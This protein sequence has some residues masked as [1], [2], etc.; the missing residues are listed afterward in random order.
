MEKFV[1]DG[2]ALMAIR[3]VILS[4]IA[5]SLLDRLCGRCTPNLHTSC[6]LPMFWRMETPSKCRIAAGPRVLMQDKNTTALLQNGI[7]L[8]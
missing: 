7:S 5:M 8:S 4:E 6:T 3:F 1:K 2:I